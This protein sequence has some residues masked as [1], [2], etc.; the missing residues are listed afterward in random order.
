MSFFMKTCSKHFSGNLE[1]NP[2]RHS[3]SHGANKY[4]RIKYS[5]LCILGEAYVNMQSQVHSRCEQVHL[6][7]EATGWATMVYW[8]PQIRVKIK[9]TSIF[10]CFRVET[11]PKSLILINFCVRGWIR[12]KMSMMFWF[13]AKTNFATLVTITGLVQPFTK[14]NEKQCF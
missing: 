5:S 8:P 1:K 10:I 14:I 9:L 11:C 13:S 12:I 7:Q 4:C 3:G 2:D 6:P